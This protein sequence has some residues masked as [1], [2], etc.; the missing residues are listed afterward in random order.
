LS[1]RL[2][3]SSTVAAVLL[4]FASI[5]AAEDA[6]TPPTAPTPLQQLPPWMT[7]DVVKSFIAMNMT[8]AQKP[9]FNKAVGQFI[10]DHF[11]MIQKE[12]KRSAP[13]L[14]M[15]IKSRDKALVHTLDNDV[16]KIL[17]QEQLPAYENYKD[18]LL[19]ALRSSKVVP[20]V[21]SEPRSGPATM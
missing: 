3:V 20:P 4:G 7:A 5:A 1:I 2:I 19:T 13:N 11:A 6:A 8:E 10:T 18:A 15:T 14:D 9:E 21:P 16:H 12:I 17:T